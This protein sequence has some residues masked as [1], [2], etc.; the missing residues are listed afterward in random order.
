MSDVEDRYIPTNTPVADL[1][2]AWA[3]G[4]HFRGWIQP[5]RDF[6]RAYKRE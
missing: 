1:R 4:V 6:A 3:K 2:P 5:M